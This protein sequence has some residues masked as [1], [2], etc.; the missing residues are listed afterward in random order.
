M[1][2]LVFIKGENF[3]KVNY[4]ITNILDEKIR[5]EDLKKIINKKLFS[6]IK[7]IEFSDKNFHH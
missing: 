3:M 7:F 2:I 4:H 1:S 5:Q 6:I